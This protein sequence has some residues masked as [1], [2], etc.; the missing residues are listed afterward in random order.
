MDFNGFKF[1]KTTGEVYSADLYSETRVGGVNGNV[2]SSVTNLRH[3]WIRTDEG[4]EFEFKGPIEIANIGHQVTLCVV[5]RSNRSAPYFVANHATDKGFL[6]NGS[7]VDGHFSNVF[8]VA[9][10]VIG[11]V[12]FGFLGLLAGN[13]GVTIGALGAIALGA[14]ISVNNGRQ[15]QTFQK[16]ILDYSWGRLG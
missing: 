13:V 3:Y 8:I 2:S 16:A 6:L 4:R 5:G 15:L 7:F 10:L 1:T 14:I 9:A 12:F 11:G